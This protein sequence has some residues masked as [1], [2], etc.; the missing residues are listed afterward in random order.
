MQWSPQQEKALKAVTRWL[1]DPHAPQVFRVFGFAGT[2]KTTLAR[3][4]AENVPGLVLAG[5]YTGKAAH[6]LRQKGFVGALTLHS[7][8][9]HPQEKAQS[10]LRRLELE[11]I[12]RRRVLGDSALVLEKED[13]QCVELLKKIAAERINLAR[14]LWTIN[15]ESSL[16]SAN[17]LIVDECSM[18]DRRM[19]E[20]LLHF[21]TRILVLGDP[22]Q[23]PSIAGTGFFTEAKPD[24]LLT[25]VHRQAADNPIIALATRVR[26]CLP[27]LPGHY[28]ESRV[29]TQ[30]ALSAQ[31]A[32]GCD[33]IL[34]GRNKTRHNYNRRIRSLLGRKGVLPEAADRIVC[35]RNN[36]ERGLLNGAVWY[37]DRV[38]PCEVG[39]GEISATI[40]PEGTAP[41]DV[42]AHAVEVDMHTHHFEERE[43]T[44]TRWELL[45]AE[46]FA[47]GYALTCHK[48]QGSQWGSVLLL[49]ESA[50][51]R[52]H[53]HRWLYTAIT[54]AA[55]RV[56]VA[57]T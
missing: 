48:A 42:R 6:V 28:G 43:T 19:G 21:G 2:G 56:V 49:D 38:E 14:P 1:R 26:E 24:I 17:L 5:A 20:D 18:V 57:Q 12:D 25:E 40:Y 36:H 53:S 39:A 15:T 30:D 34:V 50:A 22:A 32:L 23:L 55:E 35:L 31:D 3:E 27:L 9:Y 29:I 7:L 33:Q 52:Q 54:R 47:H 37:V 41:K 46:E 4:F 44:D 11:L 16:R 45:T 8:I 51:F 10:V 13:A